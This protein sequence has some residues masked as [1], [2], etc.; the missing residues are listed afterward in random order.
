MVGATSDCTSANS[1]LVPSKVQ[2]TVEP[3]VCS[4]R[5]SNIMDDGFFTS[6]RPS[7]VISNTPISLVEPNRFFTARKIRWLWWRSPSKYSTQSTMCS[8]TFGPANAP[9]F[10]TWPTTKTEIDRSFA[11]FIKESVTSRT[12]LTVPG[13]DAMSGLY[14]V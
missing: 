11:S 9:S 7:P 13:A 12:W 3:D 10:V 1:G 5:P 4:G 14:M 8:K 2:M 6:R